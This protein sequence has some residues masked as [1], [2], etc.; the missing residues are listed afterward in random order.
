MKDDTFIKLEGYIEDITFRN[1]ENGY[2]VFSVSSKGKETVCVG[3]VQGVYA[4]Q[5]AEVSGS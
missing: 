5:F 1:E 4:G 2:T 3:T